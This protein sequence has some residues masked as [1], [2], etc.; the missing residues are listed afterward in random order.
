M[1]TKLGI[2]PYEIDRPVSPSVHKARLIF[3]RLLDGFKPNSTSETTFKNIAPASLHDEV[4][5][6]FT[7]LVIN[8]FWEA[9]FSETPS[10]SFSSSAAIYRHLRDTLK[11]EEVQ[12]FVPNHPTLKRESPETH[13]KLV[14]WARKL[15]IN[16]D[17]CLDF[18][19][20]AMRS[21]LFDMGGREFK[22]W[23]RAINSDSTGFI[24]EAVIEHVTEEEI[25]GGFTLGVS[26]S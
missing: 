11:P 24:W 22:L 20:E 15:N 1:A 9:L 25:K 19:V 7:V 23:G 2:G 26:K 10:S 5:L 13:D 8:R 6:P 21:W 14:G 3:L 18:A 12:A 17:W 16:C 4:F